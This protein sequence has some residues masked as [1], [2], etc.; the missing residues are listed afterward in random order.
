M[1]AA[2]LRDERIFWDRLAG[3]PPVEAEAELLLRKEDA[4][5]ELVA[6]Q[7]LKATHDRLGQRTEAQA[8][9]V[10]MLALNKQLTVI[11]VRVKQLRKLQD[12][13]SWRRAVQALY[14]QEG[15]EACLVWIEQHV[16]GD[17]PQ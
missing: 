15:V 14:G 4:T 6:L 17:Q 16:Q 7:R 2:V 11:N 5:Q 8:A 1:T 12:R 9:G 3:M 13:T 10:E